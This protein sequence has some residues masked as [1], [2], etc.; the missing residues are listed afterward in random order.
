MSQPTTTGTKIE[1]I[2]ERC[3]GAGN[4]AEVAP[5]YFDQNDVDGTVLLKQQ[6]VDAGDEH[7]VNE[8]AEICPVAAIVVNS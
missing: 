3:M 6:H 5:K 1:V 2:H 7:D 8:A 4:C